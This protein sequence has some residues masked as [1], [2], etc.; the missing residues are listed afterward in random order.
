MTSHDRRV[1]LPPRNRPQALDIRRCSI[2]S[3]RAA[4]AF[5]RG[6]ESEPAQR[7]GRP[8]QAPG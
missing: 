6:A 1:G 2:R 8:V 3:R 5:G 4:G 7:R